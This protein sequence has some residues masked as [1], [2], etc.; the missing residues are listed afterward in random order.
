MSLKAA[1]FKVSKLDKIRK[2]K[3]FKSINETTKMLK[4]FESF[5]FMFL[6][7]NGRQ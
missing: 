6:F 4:E 3:T 7:I 5:Y 2:E 1:L